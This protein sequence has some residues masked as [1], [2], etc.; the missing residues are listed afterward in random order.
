[1]RL[2]IA[3]IA[4][5]RRP[6]DEAPGQRAALDANCHNASDSTLVWMPAGACPLEIEGDMTGGV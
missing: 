5:F 1:M 3:A 2:A 6:I 4:V